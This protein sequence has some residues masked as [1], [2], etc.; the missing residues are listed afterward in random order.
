MSA[1]A[2][3][4]ALT[5]TEII[6]LYAAAAEDDAAA[7]LRE[8]ARR[9]RKTAQS[10]ADRAWWARVSA[11]WRDFAHAQYL[12]AEEECRGNLVAREYLAEIT[13]GWQLWSGSG[14]WAAR[15][16]TEELRDFWAAHPR[17]TVSRYAWDAARPRRGTEAR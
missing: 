12:A 15:R 13:D 5:D 10:A 7:L 1:L 16:A 4:R 11:E 3:L 8:M 17:V 14:Q 2:E 9:D 6:A